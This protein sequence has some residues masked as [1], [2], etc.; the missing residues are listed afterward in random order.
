MFQIII[1]ICYLVNMLATSLIHLLATIFLPR[2]TGHPPWSI[3][4]SDQPSSWMLCHRMALPFSGLI[5]TT[6]KLNKNY[7]GC[8]ILGVQCI[9]RVISY[10][11]NCTIKWGPENMYTFSIAGHIVNV[12]KFPGPH[13]IYRFWGK[14]WG[15]EI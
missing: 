1:L 7:R 13:F 6:L 3:I 2:I 10:M 8:M 14:C 15:Y 11:F 4:M 5:K 12:Y 9:G